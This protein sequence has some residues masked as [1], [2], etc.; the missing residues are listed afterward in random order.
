MSFSLQ[1][2]DADGGEREEY[3]S[4]S[5]R[6]MADLRAGLVGVAGDDPGATVRKL[7]FN[8]GLRV[9]RDE[10]RWIADRMRL[11]DRDAI[12]RREPG[13]EELL[14]LMD[15]LAAF[16]ELCATLGGFVVE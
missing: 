11:V 8:D 6:A 7:G 3:L 10:C 13:P 9:E 14:D 2:V 12:L 15:Q 16:A 1:A 4:L 5:N